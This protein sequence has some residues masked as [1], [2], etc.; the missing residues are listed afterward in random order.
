MAGDVSLPSKEGLVD[1]ILRSLAWRKEALQASFEKSGSEVGVRF[2]AIDDLLPVEVAQSIAS[3]FP[4]VGEMRLMSS[5]REQKYTSKAYDKFHPILGDTTFAFQDPQ[6]VRIVEEIT[7]IGDQIPDSLLY[8]G[9]LSAMARG[10][11]LSPHI[12]NSHDS[13]RQYYRTLNLLYYVTL[14]WNE[15]IGGNLQLW[16]RNVSENVTIHSRFNRLVL[17]ETTP[18]SWHSVNKV[19]VD[20]VR[21]CVSNY[22]FSQRSPTGEDYFNITAFAA[23]PNR[24][25]LRLWSKVDAGLRQ[26]V[27]K[28]RPGGMGKVDL[29][30]GPPR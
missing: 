16:N 25:L 9:G 11:F 29:Y 7:G 13:S 28:L 2:V 3:A 24:P 15:A 4:D 1:L 20:G 12:D 27:R 14:D 17:M 10:H 5:F 23:P 26:Y 8:A 21:K 6:V 30:D 18:W 19:Q 22:Y